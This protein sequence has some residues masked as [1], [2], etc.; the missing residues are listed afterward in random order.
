[1][2]QAFGQFQYPTPPLVEDDDEV[3]QRVH[4]Y[5]ADR[6]EAA[7]APKPA[8]VGYDADD[9]AVLLGSVAP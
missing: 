8:A 9:L 5:L 3:L 2:R 6:K 4:R 1:M 7:A